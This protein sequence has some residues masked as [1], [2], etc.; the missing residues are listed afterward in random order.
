[1][2]IAPL[3]AKWNRHIIELLNGLKTAPV[4]E[5]LG[6]E[7]LHSLA[8]SI[9]YGYG[10]ADGLGVCSSNKPYKY[11]GVSKTI[12]PFFAEI[13]VSVFPVSVPAA[14]DSSGSSAQA[15]AKSRIPTAKT[16][17]NKYFIHHTFF[18]NRFVKITVL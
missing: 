11:L 1:M 8:E 14:G 7:G 3:C 2:D 10:A 5:N 17:A 15:R 18:R 16:I 9:I 13:D 12:L 6:K 4:V